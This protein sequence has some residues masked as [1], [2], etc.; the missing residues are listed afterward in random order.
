MP[1][2]LTAAGGAAAAGLLLGT[3][4][5]ALAR[6]QLDEALSRINMARSYAREHEMMHVYPFVEL[7]AGQVS[8]ARGE[9]ETALE[10]FNRSEELA[11]DMKMRP[12]IWQAR[13]GAAR[14]LS[15]MGRESEAAEKRQQALDMVQEIA[16]LF[17]NEEYR[18]M[19]LESAYKKLQAAVGEP[20][21]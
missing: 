16:V 1:L 14:V 9:Y 15:H 18:A 3:A 7:I 19:F 20:V 10:Q 4:A 8:A 12:S 13:A 6:N 17:K 5:V 2:L 11:L 21:A